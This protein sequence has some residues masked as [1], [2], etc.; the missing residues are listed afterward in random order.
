[1]STSRTT[2]AFATFGLCAAAVL[3]AAAMP[4][5][6]AAAAPAEGQILAVATP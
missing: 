6:G 1:M 2:R 5:Y 4:A 3:L